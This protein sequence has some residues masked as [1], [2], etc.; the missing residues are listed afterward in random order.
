MR[1]KVIFFCLFCNT[2]LLAQNYHP[3]PVATDT[4]S[5]ANTEGEVRFI[6][7]DSVATNANATVYYPHK[8]IR[9]IDDPNSTCQG[10][11]FDTAWAGYSIEL[12]GTQTTFNHPDYTL[13][14]DAT[15]QSSSAIPAGELMYLDRKFDL[16]VSFQQKSYKP[17]FNG[18]SD[19]VL[20]YI[21]S[22]TDSLGN[23][24]APA[25]NGGGVI[26]IS[27]NHGLL[28][29]PY[30][31]HTYDI[32][33]KNQYNRIAYTFLTRKAVF[34][35]EVGDVYQY[36][37]SGFK[38]ASSPPVNFLPTYTQHEIMAKTMVTNDSVVYQIKRKKSFYQINFTTGINEFKVTND[39]I[40]QSFGRLNQRMSTKLSHQADTI[41]SFPFE[42]PVWLKNGFWSR[43][44]IV[45]LDNFFEN[46]ATCLRYAFEA[47]NNMTYYHQGL[48]LTYQEGYAYAFATFN[49]YEMIYFSKAG[50]QTGG[51]YK[52]IGLE[53]N[54]EVLPISFY[55]NPVSKMLNVVL[56]KNTLT[57]E[58]KVYN[59]TGQLLIN[60]VVNESNTL[61]N[62]ENLPSGIYILTYKSEQAKF[63]K[64]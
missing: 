30:Y 51:S 35:Y 6:T 19:T 8:E 48:G 24:L 29:L 13:F 40:V 58:V 15:N 42:H 57:Q 23:A 4:F 22:G 46:N 34:N 50:G 7:F 10:H 26:E 3:F 32:F 9:F 27:R 18:Q 36:L 63:I 5:F 44:G 28:S 45:F 2:L 41:S 49:A 16:T 1:V 52:N 53:E 25:G 38:F 39:T 11:L 37:T 54:A 20:T 64:L 12:I 14:F 21:L 47:A 33:Q 59:S 55:P 60:T 43:D 61:L 31:F 62:V 56:P 17:I